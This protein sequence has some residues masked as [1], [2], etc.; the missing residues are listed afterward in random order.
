[1]TR[2]SPLSP[3]D[4]KR[5]ASLAAKL[6]FPTQNA[7]LRKLDTL[8][9]ASSVLYRFSFD[10]SAGPKALYVKLAGTPIA[11]A[12]QIARL[13]QECDVT[14]RVRAMMRDHDGL[15]TVSPVGYID[16]FEAFVTRETPGRPLLGMIQA[17]LRFRRSHSLPRLSGLARLAGKWLR[18]FHSVAPLERSPDFYARQ[19]RYCDYRIDTLTASSS[20]WIDEREAASLRDRIRK[21]T[22]ILEDTHGSELRLCHN[23]YSPHNIMAHHENIHVLDF[24][25]ATA[26]LPLF[27]QMCFWHK[28]EELKSSPLYAMDAIQTLQTAFLTGYGVDLRLNDPAAKLGVTRLLLNKLIT[29]AN[30]KPL[31]PDRLLESL[32]RRQQH[33]LTLKSCLE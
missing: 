32:A 8:S 10:I 22:S 12:A 2:T 25:F 15:N 6:A 33:L 13:R 31:R 7:V 11:T 17:E 23:D 16:E 14:L 26:S 24:S 19:V 20:P 29:L 1:M 3:C 9:T 21:W 18:E 5:L 27:D 30:E 28:L 4:G